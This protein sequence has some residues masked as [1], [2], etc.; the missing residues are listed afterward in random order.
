MKNV[1]DQKPTRDLPAR[2]KGCA[3]FVSKNGIHGKTVLDVGCG[4]GSFVLYALENGAVQATGVEITENDIKTAK[5][6]IHSEKINFLVGSAIQIPVS[7][8]S[9]D[10]VVSFD[11][12][13]HIP[14][15]T[16]SQ[17]FSEIMRVLKPGGSF[18]LSTPFQSIGSNI[19][20]PAWFLVG[21]RHY[22]QKELQKFGADQGFI[23]K[24]VET[25][26]SWW[27]FFG[28]LNMYISKWIFRRP[29]FFQKLF[30]KKENEEYL[31]REGFINIFVH[32]KK[33][34]L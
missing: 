17:M 28:I 14:K 18:Y 8:S 15:H 9:F 26:G 13:E 19:C 5:E 27:T 3:D 2:L 1:L 25:R 29:L 34:L 23:T 30:Q 7:D 24:L 16:E 22:S 12:I 20:D 11:V 31:K 10:T 33:P 32:Y 4:F 6:N 21:H